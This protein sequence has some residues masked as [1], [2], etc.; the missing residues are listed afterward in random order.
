MIRSQSNSICVR[1][2]RLQ[3]LRGLHHMF[4]QLSKEDRRLFHPA[5]V[6]YD[7][8]SVRLLL[9][10]GLLITNSSSGLRSILKK[11]LPNLVRIDLVA[12]DHEGLI[13]GTAFLKFDD[14]TCAQLG[15]GLCASARGKGIGSIL[16]RRL[17]R[18]GYNEGVR[19]YWLTVMA[20][21]SKAIGMYEN[22]GFKRTG[23]LLEKWEQKQFDSYKMEL[24]LTK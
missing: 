24:E 17:L 10:E 12:V 6:V 7:S 5:Y 23:T 19:K 3:D 22:F 11:I 4:G 2:L 15:I 9:N 18:E 21:N 20:D 14:R 13:L 8:V 16:M 1:Y